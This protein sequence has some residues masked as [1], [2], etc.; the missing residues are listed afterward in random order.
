MNPE[1]DL[2]R[3]RVYVTAV[4]IV[5]ESSAIRNGR[6]VVQSTERGC[7]SLMKSSKCLCSYLFWDT[8]G[9]RLRKAASG[10]RIVIARGHNQRRLMHW[11][12]FTIEISPALYRAS[13]Y[14]LQNSDRLSLACARKNLTAV[15]IKNLWNFHKP[16]AN[17]SFLYIALIYPNRQDSVIKAVKLRCPIFPTPAIEEALLTDIPD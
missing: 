1:R 9:M 15:K 8:T 4:A 2:K 10:L 14:S 5:F 17:F 13:M 16:T 12:C 6:K 7:A 3:S 11:D